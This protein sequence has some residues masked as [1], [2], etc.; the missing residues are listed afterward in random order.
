MFRGDVWDVHFPAPIGSRPCVVLTT[1][2]LID[3]L[4]AVTVAEVISTEGPGSTHI[5]LGHES[6]LTGRAQSWANVTGLHT[7]PKGKLRR[8]RGRLAPAELAHVGAAVRGYL[9]L[10]DD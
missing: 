2:A 6:G 4:G 5:E 7:V 9:D 3:R 1:N 10:D 8:Q